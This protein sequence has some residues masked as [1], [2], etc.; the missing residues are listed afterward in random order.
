MLVYGPVGEDAAEDF[1]MQGLDAPVE[2]RRKSREILNVAH[3]DPR[4]RSMRT[5]AASGINHHALRDERLRKLSA[6]AFVGKRKKR[7][8]RRRAG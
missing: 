4:L 5:R 6:A 7:G 2:E 3:I 8:L 1:G